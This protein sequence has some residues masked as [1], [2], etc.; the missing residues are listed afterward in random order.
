[1]PLGST[2]TEDSY[3][4]EKARMAQIPR[5]I[6]GYAAR[7]R[8]VRNTVEVIAA[9]PR[10]V[11]TFTLSAGRPYLPCPDV[12][13]DGYEDR[14]R[15]GVLG[16]TPPNVAALKIIGGAGTIWQISAVVPRHAAFCRGAR[17]GC[18]QAIHGA[19]AIPIKRTV[20]LPTP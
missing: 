19:T 16:I 5:A 9:D 8:T 7:H 10:A 3:E 18:R 13:G 1:M 20:F 14:S 2:L 12:D 11:R 4:R 15:Y 6:I 17:W